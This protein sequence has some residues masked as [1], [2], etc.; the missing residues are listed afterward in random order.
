MEGGL[1]I[2]PPRFPACVALLWLGATLVWWGFAFLPLPSQP[3]AWLT[4][5][6]AA[7]FGATDQGLPEAQGW[8]L[9]VLAPATFLGAMLVLWGAE[10]G[11]SLRAAAR[12]R[13]G[14]V[15]L[16]V[17]ALVVALE[18]SWVARRVQAA[19]AVTAWAEAMPDDGELPPDYPRQSQ[20]APEVALVDQHRERVSLARFL[21]RPVVVTFVFAHCQTL[22]PLIVDTLKRAAPPG[23]GAEVLLVSL[24]PWRDTP[25]SLPGIAERWALPANFRILS[26]RAA[27]EV[28]AVAGA[29]G[30]PFER[31]AVSGDITHPGLVF[32]I[33]P[34]GRLAYTLNSPSPAWVREALQRVGGGHARAG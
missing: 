33:D 4:S 7:C 32:L 14:R 5:A 17:L 11:A 9:L 25:G 16:A 21:G 8:M 18:A 31:D 15:G 34:Q 10:L 20:P 6:R 27:D 1:A 29:Y 26:S 28:L 3:P 2:R 12:S 23:P 24:D 13:A 30:V 19:R 22:C